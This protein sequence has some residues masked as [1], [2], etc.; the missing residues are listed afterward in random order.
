M[1]ANAESSAQCKRKAPQRTVN[2]AGDPR[3][4]VVSDPLVRIVNR[5]LIQIRPRDSSALPAD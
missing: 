2:R 3:D 1:K 5:R 4:L